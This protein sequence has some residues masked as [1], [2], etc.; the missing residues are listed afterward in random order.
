MKVLA[1]SVCVAVSGWAMTASAQ[2]AEIE[3]RDPPEAVELADAQSV[4]GQRYDSYISELPRRAAP[5]AIP[6]SSLTSTGV[7]SEPSPAAP[8]A[9]APL[10]MAYTIQAGAFSSY[11]N[12]DLQAV[13]LRRYGETR[14][15]EGVTN[16]RPIYRVMLGGWVSREQAA[17]MLDLIKARGFEGFVTR[18]S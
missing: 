11:E 5:R 1:I 16:G 9:A 17:P 10:S 2:R 4:M 7:V 3:Y 18:A 12:A 8:A 14:I 15:V 6:T 13:A